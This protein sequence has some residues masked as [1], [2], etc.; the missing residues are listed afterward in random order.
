MPV[1]VSVRRL[2]F[3]FVLVRVWVSVSVNVLGVCVYV[4]GDMYEPVP[5][6]VPPG[7]VDLKLVSPDI[8]VGGGDRNEES[9]GRVSVAEYEP[10]FE[11]DDGLDPYP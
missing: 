4:L 2:V 9:V 8:D 7:V 11:G 10:V 3:V 6:Y 5:R 1:L